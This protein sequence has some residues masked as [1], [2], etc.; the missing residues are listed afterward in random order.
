MKSTRRSVIRSLFLL[1][2]MLV[3]ST[4]AAGYRWYYPVTISGN[5]VAGS[6]GSARNSGNSNEYIGCAVYGSSTRAY[7]ICYAQ[8]AA[9]TTVSCYADPVLAPSIVTTVGTLNGD[10]FLSF[11]WDASGNCTKVN[12]SS[13]SYYEPKAP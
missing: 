9:G 12:V 2:A 6:L 13:R 3:A 8:D 4:A 11:S 10:G 5:N 7:A 1:A